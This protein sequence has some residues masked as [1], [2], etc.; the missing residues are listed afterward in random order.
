MPLQGLRVQAGSAGGAGAAAALLQEAGE[1][2]RKGDGRTDGR[3]EAG[4]GTRPRLPAGWQPVQAARGRHGRTP[5]PAVRGPR[6]LSDSDSRH[7]AAGDAQPPSSGARVRQ[8]CRWCRGC[9]EPGPTRERRAA[10]DREGGAGGQPSAP[11]RRRESV[12]RTRGPR[13]M[14]TYLPAARPGC[15]RVRRSPHIRVP[16]DT[17]LLL[18][19]PSPPRG[20][21][22][23]LPAA[24]ATPPVRWEL[25]G[26]VVGAL[27]RRSSSAPARPRTKMA[28]TL[29]ACHAVSTRAET[30]GR[31]GKASAVHT[32]RRRGGR[33]GVRA[34]GGGRL[35]GGGSAPCW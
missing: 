18:P 35:R 20:T 3:R 31:R 22:T 1:R 10:A 11:R 24:A 26:A 29:P 2:R 30:A 34:A 7:A 27:A 16:G 33:P 9:E 17:Q 14:L 19:R 4:A 21:N 6:L 8:P 15:D 32:Q 23:K 5:P 25:P 13:G 12:A 28:A